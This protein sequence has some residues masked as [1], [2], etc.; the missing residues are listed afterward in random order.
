MAQLETS[1]YAPSNEAEL[2]AMVIK[3]YKD[4]IPLKIEGGSTRDGLGRPFQAERSLSMRNLSGITLY[5]PSEMII[6]AKAGTPLREIE[7]AL[8]E[9]GQMFAFEPMDHRNLLGSK[10]EPTI[11]AIA[12]TNASGPRRIVAGAARD[13]LVGVRFV[14]GRG[15]I[16]KNGG[17][18][19]KNVTGLDLVKLQAGAFGTLGVLSEVIFKV[20]PK[21]E[22]TAT[23]SFKGLSDAQAVS[24]MAQAQG[25]PYEITAA[26]HLTAG[27]GRDTS[28]SFIRIEGFEDSVNYRLGELRRLLGTFG[29]PSE[30]RGNDGARLWAGIRDVE[31]LSEPC[32]NMVWRICVKPTD[33]PVLIAE[34]QAQFSF[35]HYFDWGGGLIWLSCD[36]QLTDA[37]KRIRSAAVKFQGHARLERAPLEHRASLDVFQP[38]SVPL[39]QLTAGIKKSLDPASILNSGRMYAGI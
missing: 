1:S 20:L 31:F 27:M 17:R 21:P 23:L 32:E 10:G 3:A 30:L 39:M 5:E 25:S 18:V 33:A 19:M 28:R 36:S 29:E 26:A 15:E 6:G 37:A 16:I 9:K 2:S 34:L 38:L 4:K 11:G 24:M 35:K 7:A 14:N 22:T 13:S 8:N 12:A